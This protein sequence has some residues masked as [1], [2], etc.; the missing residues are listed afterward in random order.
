MV[1]Y[2]IAWNFQKRVKP[3]D[4]STHMKLFPASKKLIIFE[5][6]LLGDLVRPKSGNGNLLVIPDR[7]TTLERTIKLKKIAMT[8]VAVHLYIIWFSYAYPRRW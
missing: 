6:D 3:W 8:T 1:Q 5:I 2:D 4:T 7:F